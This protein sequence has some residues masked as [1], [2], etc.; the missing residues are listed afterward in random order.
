[1]SWLAT[2]LALVLVFTT[3]ALII[4]PREETS[5]IEWVLQ[6]L[7]REEVIRDVRRVGSLEVTPTSAEYGD[8]V[9]LTV[10]AGTAQ[11]PRSLVMISPLGE[12]LEV[13]YDPLGREIFTIPEDGPPGDYHFWLAGASLEAGSGLG[14]ITVEVTPPPDYLLPEGE[15]ETPEEEAVVAST[16]PP[17]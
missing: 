12:H 3:N 13:R 1:M 4:R 16:N 7:R 17:G 8:Q 14:V 15:V 5:D 6:E 2:L 9:M 11:Q 10:A